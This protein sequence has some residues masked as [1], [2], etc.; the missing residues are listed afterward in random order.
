VTLTAALVFLL[1]LAGVRLWTVGHQRWEL[2]SLSLELRAADPKARQQAAERLS[3]IGPPALPILVDALGDPRGEV[4]Q[5][6][7]SVV[8]KAKPEP[9]TA[10]QAL[11]QAAADPEA[12]VRDVAVRELGSAYLQFG[13]EASAEGMATSV[14]TLRKALGDPEP[15]VRQ[16]AA[17]TLAVFG[18][19]AGPAA[20]DLGVALGDRDP[21]VRLAAARSLL[22]IDRGTRGRVMPILLALLG[23]VDL[24]PDPITGGV[25]STSSGAFG[26]ICELETQAEAV[27]VLVERLGRPDA[28]VRREAASYLEGIGSLADE[29]IPAL[30]ETLDDDDREARFAAA[31]ALVRI[32]PDVA[33]ATAVPVLSQLFLDPE[34]G[35]IPRKQVLEV[36]RELDPEAIAALVSDLIEGLRRDEGPRRMDD[37]SLLM[38]IGPRA[39]EAVPA[40]IR[41]GRN[42]D[43]PASKLANKAVLQIDPDAAA[44]LMK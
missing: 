38:A 28:R 18:R 12:R 17:D 20:E 8:L 35:L 25:F 21:A 30:V 32:D 11:V 4:R 5:L 33:L 16:A 24:R 29:A 3:A 23:E 1:G 37:I 40:L 44:Q 15:T 2:R 9:S 43:D 10:I 6:A 22:R 13:L 34:L 31:R 41:I 19:E 14:A 26:T 42:A 36:L 7:C 39:R 27:P